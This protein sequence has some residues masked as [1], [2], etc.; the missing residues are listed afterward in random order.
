MIYTIA[1]EW[2]SDDHGRCAM[3]VMMTVMMTTMIVTMMARRA[4][5]T[6]VHE[7]LAMQVRYI[8]HYDKVT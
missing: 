7:L 4:S 6:F 1:L 2:S 8:I 5:D 3:T